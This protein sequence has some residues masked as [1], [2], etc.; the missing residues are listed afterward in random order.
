MQ[1]RDNPPPNQPPTAS[2]AQ[3]TALYRPEVTRPFVQSLTS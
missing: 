2:P 1:G 3:T